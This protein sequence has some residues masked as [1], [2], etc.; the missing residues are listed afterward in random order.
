M[1]G[2]LT[3][4]N[5]FLLYETDSLMITIFNHSRIIEID[6]QI[7]GKAAFDKT[8]TAASI[9]SRKSS[10]FIERYQTSRRQIE[11][12]KFYFY[13][14]S[15]FSISSIFVFYDSLMNQTTAILVIVNCLLFCGTAVNSVSFGD[16]IYYKRKSKL[17]GHHIPYG[18]MSML[19]ALPSDFIQLQRGGALYRKT[20]RDLMRF[21]S[22]E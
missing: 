18:R 4:L 3:L 13:I 19:F 7:Y 16:G 17:G 15:N 12:C 22:P 1:E 5:K 2:W 8:A 9:I 14:F 20:R 10:M 6:F 21:W 11:S